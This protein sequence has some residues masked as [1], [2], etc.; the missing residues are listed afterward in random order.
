MGNRVSQDGFLC[1][2]SDSTRITK[3]KSPSKSI[4]I[5]CNVDLESGKD[6]ALT[7]RQSMQI[8]SQNSMH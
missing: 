3:T 2:S 7:E 6:K 1:K 4:S 5:R 8:D